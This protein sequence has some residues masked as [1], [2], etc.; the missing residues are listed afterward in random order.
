MGTYVDG[1][2]P[3]IGYFVYKCLH[4]DTDYIRRFG[5]WGFLY[6]KF[7][8]AFAEKYKDFD[9]ENL[10]QYG[11]DAGTVTGE[12]NYHFVIVIGTRMDE[13]YETVSK[14]DSTITDLIYKVDSRWEQIAK[15]FFAFAMKYIKMA[16]RG[17]IE[18]FKENGKFIKPGRF[19]ETGQ[20]FHIYLA[21]YLA[22]KLEKESQEP[23]TKKAKPAI[24]FKML[25]DEEYDEFIKF[26]KIPEYYCQMKPGEFV[27]IPL[28]S[29]SWMSIPKATNAC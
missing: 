29:W 23:D 9:L 15:D 24:E 27:H 13:T 18:L 22:K 7:C 3:L 6:V 16:E 19:S 20:Q 11:C 1:A 12:P 25:T 5:V 14:P 2:F 28:F 4:Y 10:L 8:E 21:K 17:E 26:A